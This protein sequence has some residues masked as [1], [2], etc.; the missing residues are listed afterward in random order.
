MGFWTLSTAWY[1]GKNIMLQT[2]E[3]FPSSS[4]KVG[5]YYRVMSLR[6]VSTS[7][8]GKSLIGRVAVWKQL[9]LNQVAPRHMLVENK[10]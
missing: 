10:S 3:F 7:F 8:Y 1:S 9:S 4:K 6:L 5:N 2:L